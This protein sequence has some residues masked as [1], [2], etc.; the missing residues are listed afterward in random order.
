M[1]YPEN[2]FVLAERGGLELPRPFRV[3]REEIRPRFG[4]L[5]GS[6]EKA[7][8]P[9]KICSPGIRLLSGYRSFRS[10]CG[11]AESGSVKH[12]TRA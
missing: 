1:L 12:Q 4:P 7:S 3:S 10:L 2:P 9:E 11:C 8:M 5:S 6:K